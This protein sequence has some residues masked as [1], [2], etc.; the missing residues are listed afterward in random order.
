MLKVLRFTFKQSLRLPCCFSK[1][2]QKHGFLQF[3]LTAVFGVRNFENTS[4]MRTIFLLEIFE[5]FTYISKMPKKLEEKLSVL[6]IIAS[7][8]AL[9]NS[10]Y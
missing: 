9:L 8:L 3:Y 2:L 7:H 6:E 1:G 5:T 4:A 10:L